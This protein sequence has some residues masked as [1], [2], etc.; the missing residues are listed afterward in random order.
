V[1]G[2]T[3]LSTAHGG[4]IKQFDA[5]TECRSAGAQMS[6]SEIDDLPPKYDSTTAKCK[7]SL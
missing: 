5:R 3:A 2:P 4:T 1:D 6:L 7:E